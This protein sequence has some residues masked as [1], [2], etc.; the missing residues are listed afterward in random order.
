MTLF[1]D[2]GSQA[3]RI[4]LARHLSELFQQRMNV[5][6]MARQGGIAGPALEA[7]PLAVCRQ[8][9]R[10]GNSRRRKRGRGADSAVSQVLQERARTLSQALSVCVTL[11][12]AWASTEVAAELCERLLVHLLNRQAVPIGP[13]DEVLRRSQISARGNRGVARFRQCV[14]KPVEQRAR[15]TITKCTNSSPAWVEVR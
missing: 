9:N 8:E 12:W 2:K 7:H 14:G 5:P 11:M 3:V 15:R 4:P 10:I 1:Q 13:V 6:A